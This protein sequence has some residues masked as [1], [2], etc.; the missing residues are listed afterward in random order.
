MS[1]GRPPAPEDEGAGAGQQ[2]AGWGPPQEPA[3]RPAP[4]WGQYAPAGDDGTGGYGPQAPGSGAP[5]PGSGSQAPG[6]GSQAPGYG[7]QAPGYGSQ[8]GPWLE[9]GPAAGQGYGQYGQYGQGAPAP[10]APGGQ[11]GA[12]YGP[13]GPAHGWA[14]APRPGIIPLRPLSL[15]ELL[16]GAFRAIRTNPRVMFG[17]SA[18]VVTVTALAQLA[19][20]WS[21]YADLEALVVTSETAADTAAM[22]AAF[23]DLLGQLGVAFGAQTIAAVVTTVLSGLLIISV[24]QSVLGRKASVGEV[25]ATARGQIARL[26][27]LSLLVLLIVV[28]PLVP[29]AGFTI[30]AAAQEQWALAGAVGLLGGLGA[31]VAVGFLLTR[32]VLATP[33]LMLERAGIGTALRRAWALTRGTFWRVLGIYL[34]TA[35]L[36]SVVAGAIGGTASIFLQVVAA[37]PAGAVFTPTYLIGTTLAQIVATALTTPFTAAVVALLYIDVRMRTEGL[38]LELARAAEQPS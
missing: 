17:L 11:A 29:W 35:L 38:D 27:V 13:S 4:R 18:V 6:Y 21:F 2:E 31:V 14:P 20:T 33:A 1:E 10:G 34:L 36:V 16:D 30:A 22:D 32:T 28:S 23:A 26:L 7:A 25:W 9:H 37:D 24:S 15:G 5:G 3:S 8:G 19:L 12:A